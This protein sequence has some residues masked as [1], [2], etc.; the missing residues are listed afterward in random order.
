MNKL[1]FEQRQKA[2]SAPQVG[3]D[4]FSPMLPGPQSPYAPA[5]RTQ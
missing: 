1:L 5:P 4:A 2:G 3:K